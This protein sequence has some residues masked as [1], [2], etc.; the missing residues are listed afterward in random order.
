MARQSHRRD[1]PI[2]LQSR[3]PRDPSFVD[4]FQLVHQLKGLEGVGKVNFA[5]TGERAHL[6]VFTATEDLE[7]NKR[8]FRL[9][10]EFRAAR[11]NVPIEIHLV[12]ADR[13]D[14]MDLP[15]SEQLL[16]N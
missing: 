2:P 11:P 15:P 16:P 12:P 13:V 5:G 8:V 6:W 3:L 10:R 9:E 14:E 4:F 1:A 7:L